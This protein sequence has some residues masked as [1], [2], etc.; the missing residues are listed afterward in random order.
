MPRF[1]LWFYGLGVIVL[2]W[3]ILQRVVDFVFAAGTA[4][5]TAIGALF[6]AYVMYP[7]V[8]RLNVRLPLW[9]AI[10]IPYV[11]CAALIAA[12]AWLFLP[13]LVNDVETLVA[14]FP[15]FVVDEHRYLLHPTDPLLSRIPEVLRLDLAN[16]PERTVAYFRTHLFGL[17]A[18]AFATV[19]S[20]ADIAI[21]VVAIPVASIYMLSEAERIKRFFISLI[22]S[23]I[24]PKTLD[25]LTD[26]NLAVGGYVR[27]QLIVAGTVGVLASILLSALHVPYAQ[28]VGL[29]AGLADILPYIGPF[30]GAIPGI[31]LAI[32][33]NGIT[34][35]LLVLAGFVAINQ[36]EAHL[37]LPRI[38]A[39]TV[40]LTPLTVIFALIV[41]GELFGLPGLLVAVPVAGV[42]RVLLDHFVPSNPVTNAELRPAL[43]QIPRVDVDPQANHT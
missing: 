14:A 5:G 37:L 1:A 15:H 2:G 25:I 38:I 4:T 13:P 8:R 26:L 22:P 29:W 35:G 42:I 20:A 43:T 21:L 12:G 10:T 9:A 17:S 30:A 41:G 39:R 36:L 11:V 23:R 16:A 33:A 27:G 34:N 18:W 6:I 40:N 32:H 19:R 24:R 31:A 3:L 28:L 7:V